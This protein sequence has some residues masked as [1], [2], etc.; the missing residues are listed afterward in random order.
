M[1]FIGQIQQLVSNIGPWFLHQRNIGTLLESYGATLDSAALSLEQGLRLSQPLR[2][3]VSALPVLS[4]DRKIRL[5]P[6]EPQQSQRF[7]LSQWKQLHRTR[8]T[9]IGE[10]KHSQPYFLPSVP[11]MRIVHQDGAGGSATWWTLDGTGTPSVHVATPSNFNYDGQVTK[12]SRFWVI[13]YPPAGLVNLAHYDDG[14]TYDST[15]FYDGVAVTQ[16]LLDLV[17]MILEWQAPHS[18][19][20]AYILATDP[21]SFDPTAT[22]VTDPSGWTS[23]PT[24]NWGSPLSPGPVVGRARPPSALWI[25]D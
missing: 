24:G 25:F 15:D 16:I 11:V 5:Y 22:A 2:C 8:A 6:T 19:L 20:Q 4:A 21:A 7:R 1:S 17:A 10:L 14:S 13:L 23:L 9:H 18:R 12:W 3:D